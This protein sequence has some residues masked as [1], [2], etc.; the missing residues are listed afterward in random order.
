MSRLSTKKE[1]QIPCWDFLLRFTTKML[2]IKSCTLSSM[3][4]KTSAPKTVDD[5]GH[6]P[7][8][9]D[10]GRSVFE[11]SRCTSLF[12]P[13]IQECHSCVATHDLRV[14]THFGF[15]IS[16]K[17]WSSC[18]GHKVALTQN[19]SVSPIQSDRNTRSEG[20]SISKNIRRCV[21]TTSQ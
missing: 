10:Y 7:N 17:S 2:K 3:A 13:K 12:A 4:K 16:T 6:R 14:L 15:K 19:K 18:L 8:T 5:V 21:P 20:I 1:A 9:V 11:T